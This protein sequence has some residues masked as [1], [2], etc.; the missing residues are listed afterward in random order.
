MTQFADRFLVESSRLKDWNYSNPGIYFITICT[1]NHGN[2][3]GKVTNNKIFLSEIGNIAKQCLEEIPSHFKYT[4]LLNYVVMPNHLHF[5]LNVETP[6]LASLQNNKVVNNIFIK[7][8]SKTFQLL[9][10]KSK[11]TIPKIIQ[12][13]KSSVKRKINKKE[14]FFAWQSRYHDI[15]VKDEKELHNLMTYIVNNPKLWLKDSFHN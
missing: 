5:L 3:F 4:K 2:F 15:I 13:Y 6:D 12:Q 14:K 8:Q 10:I 1:L 11:Q 7:S 9:N